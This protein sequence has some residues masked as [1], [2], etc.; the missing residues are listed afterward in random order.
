MLLEDD[1]APVVVG[2]IAG[3]AAVVVGAVVVAAVVAGAVVVTIVVV[4]GAVVVVS[5]V[6]VVGS[7]AVVATV[8]VAG[9]VAVSEVATVRVGV[10]RV[11][12]VRV[13]VVRVGVVRVNPVWVLSAP[14]PPPPPQAP[15]AN[16]AI[17]TRTSKDPIRA[18]LGSTSRPSPAITA[19][20]LRRAEFPALPRW[21][22][23]D[24]GPSSAGGE[25]DRLDL[26]LRARRQRRD[27]D[28]C[29]GGRLPADMACVDLV[30]GGEV[31]EVGE[32]DRRL[33]EPVEPAA[34]LLEDRAQ[35]REHLLGLLRDPSRELRRARLQPE[36][37]G[38]EDE[39][40]RHDRLRVRRALE[41]GRRSA[42]CEPPVS[43]PSALPP[44]PAAL[45]QGHPERLEDRLEHVLRL[46]AL[47]Q[48]HVQRQP[49]ALREL[50]Q[51]GRDHIARQARDPGVG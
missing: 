24:P 21:D 26:D 20:A 45:R 23:R 30:H 46:R 18:S 47:D 9:W 49:R 6:V 39:A 3:G 5:T 8:V 13:A 10:V 22:D 12:V 44:L 42:R 35:V 25:R 2:E 14:P 1:S 31:A 29:A 48:A 17:A 33:D 11:G 43:R 15:S 27:L 16:P 32:E 41:R 40:R 4:A 38:D 50:V 19:R 51:E 37:A 28:G 36:L 7:V 34:G